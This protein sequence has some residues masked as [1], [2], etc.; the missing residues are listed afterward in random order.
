M[1]QLQSGTLLQGGKYKIERVLGQGSFGIT[2]QVV[3]T[4]LNKQM[5]IKE[6][7]MGELNS[8]MEDGSVIGITDGSLT[9]N[10]KIKFRKEAQN[11][12]TM[13]HP[14]IIRIT[15]CFDENSTC[16]Y[17]MDYIE[18][19]NLND[20]VKSNTIS[21]E[22]AIAIINKV[23]DA[24]I[25]MHEEKHMLHLDLKPGNIMRRACDGHIFLIDFGLSKHFGSDGQPETSTTIGLGTSGYAP[26]EQGVRSKNGEFRPTIDVYSLG[27]TLFKLLT[28]E[29]P[30]VASDIVSDDGIL[31]ERMDAYGVTS[32]LKDIIIKAMMPSVRKRTAT[33]RKFKQE[34]ELIGLLAS[35]D[36][37]YA[38]STSDDDCINENADIEE[39]KF[40]SEDKANDDNRIDSFHARNSLQNDSQETSSTYTKDENALRKE[41]E[42]SFDK[43]MITILHYAG[44]FK[45]KS[46]RQSKIRWVSL[47]ISTI[48]AFIGLNFVPEVTEKIE[49]QLLLSI[50]LGTL[51]IPIGHIIMAFVDKPRYK[52]AM[53]KIKEDYI[54]NYIK[55]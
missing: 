24:L 4:V 48:L 53:N 20:Y 43:D 6:F 37:Y 2:Y 1:Q 8:R 45:E 12:A 23:A 22:D 26:I 44:F 41:A 9:S 27:A 49:V 46:K 15:D 16:Y 13:N 35:T 29:T 31:E 38:K 33:I 39:T 3:H 21:Q 10:Y 30:P 28:G 5:A 36:N 52:E 50:F 32:P 54:N 47:I 19:Q 40:F 25:Y 17:V 18:G 51:G 34:L 11:L 7:F 42:E 55:K 14:N